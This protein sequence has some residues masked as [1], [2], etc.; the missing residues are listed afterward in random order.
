MGTKRTELEKL[1][2]LKIG[3]QQKQAGPYR[4]PEG[5]FERRE[6]RRR[7]REAGLV[8][9]AVKLDGELVSRLRERARTAGGDMNAVV[10]E[11]LAKGLDA[12]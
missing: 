2:G 4:S 11:L 9:F 5:G 7:E 1:K 8:P 12:K 3:N 10:A 6:R